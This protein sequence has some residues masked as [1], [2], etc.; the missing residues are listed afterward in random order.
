VYLALSLCRFFLLSFFGTPPKRRVV[1]QEEEIT[2][3]VEAEIT[4]ISRG[5]GGT[6][7]DIIPMVDFTMTHAGL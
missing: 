2:H 3:E 6:Y 7:G 5:V 4:S 1:A